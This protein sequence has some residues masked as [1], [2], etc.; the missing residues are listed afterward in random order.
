VASGAEARAPIRAVMR[1]VDVFVPL[2]TGDPTT[3]AV[4]IVGEIVEARAANTQ[5][6][7]ADQGPDQV[8]RESCIA[9]IILVRLLQL[10]LIALKPLDIA[11]FAR[12]VSQAC[13]AATEAR[14]QSQALHRAK[15]A[16]R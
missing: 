16:A 9:L 13:L 7:T 11:E 1:K 4:D 2:L 14:V 12:L 8:I 3:K 10:K 5:S 6:M 15:A